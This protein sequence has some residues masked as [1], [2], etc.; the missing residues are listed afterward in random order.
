MG[1]S[2]EYYFHL[3]EYHPEQEIVQLPISLL[4]HEM[5]LAPSHT[6]NSCRPPQ[7]PPSLNY[8]ICLEIGRRIWMYILHPLSRESQCRR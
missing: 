4:L 1:Y 7:E 2:M 6:N 8:F 3:R 5:L